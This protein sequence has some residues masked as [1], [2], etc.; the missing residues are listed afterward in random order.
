MRRTSTADL[1]GPFVVVGLLVYALLRISYES[2]PPLS[3]VVAV[4][5]GALAVI[6]F[7]MPR[8]V[9]AAVGHRSGAR[10]MEAVVIARCAALGK[11]SAIVA[12]MVGGAAVGV[13]VRVVPDATRVDA[14]S[15]D[16][17]V[18]VAI[19]VADALLLAAGLMLEREAIDPASRR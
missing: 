17:R 19:L 4:P 11:A 15:S 5:L 6:E 1:L 8:R 9:L 13:L 7:V 18:A 2:L 3:Y 10:P 14:A 12:A 16:L